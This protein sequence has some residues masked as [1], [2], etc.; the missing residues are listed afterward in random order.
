MTQ[1]L[2][3]THR[4]L[5]GRIL[6][7]DELKFAIFNGVRKLF[8]QIVLKDATGVN[9]KLFIDFEFWLSSDRIICAMF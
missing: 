3:E 2:L 7:M 6:R 9:L 1:A 8:V 4:D 5:E